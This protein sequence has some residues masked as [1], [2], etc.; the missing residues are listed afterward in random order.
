MRRTH[1]LI[2][3]DEKLIR[4]SL[5]QRFHEEG[6]VTAEAETGKDGLALMEETTFDLIMLDYKLPDTTGLQVLRQI[7]QLDTDVVVIMMTAY[8]NVEDAVEAI[9]LGAYDYVAKPFRIDELM[10][11]VEKGLE[12]TRLKR[13]VRDF[14]RQIQEKF[15]TGRIIGRCPA[16]QALMQTVQ[17]VAAGGSSTVF[18]RGASGTGKDLVAKVI[19][20]NS[21]RAD[22]PFMNITCTALAENLLESELFGHEKGSFTDAK[23]Q[24]KGLLELADGGTVF[25]DEVG[26]MPPGLQAKLLRFLE[27]RAFRRVGGVSDIEVDVRVIAATNRDIET[28][29]KEGRFREDLFYRVN[30]IPITLPPLCERGDDI[31]LLTNHFLAGFAQEF[32]K[33]ITGLTEAAWQTL[34]SYTWPGNV[35]ELRNAIERAVLLSKEPVL[36]AGDFVLG[37]SDQQ[38]PRGI[39]NLH[40]PVGGVDLQEVEEQ[41]VRQAL[42]RANNNQSKAA[43]LLHISRD[44]L[45]Y[46]M[47]KFDLLKP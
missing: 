41:L 20:Y 15:G 2:I 14:R 23:S 8:S 13:Q 5:I 40:L 11:T 46:R 17:D 18:L 12:A 3:E 19:H 16:M 9:R 27:E 44:Q 39:R 24:K 26:D 6:Y 4:W 7:R 22:R 45:R 29:V 30:I 37:M 1:V 43:R 10:M 34:K 21:E 38:E 25:L 33:E 32:R 47:E 28:A 36:D 31:E 35:R 42:Q